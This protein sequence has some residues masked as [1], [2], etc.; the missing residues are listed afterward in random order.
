MH[1]IYAMMKGGIFHMNSWYLKY[2]DTLVKTKNLIFKI[3][4]FDFNS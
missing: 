4:F 3:K 2:T 1:F